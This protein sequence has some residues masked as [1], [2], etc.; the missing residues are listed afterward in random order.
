MDAAGDVVINVTTQML[1][2][3]GS[4]ISVEWKLQKNLIM[5]SQEY[6]QAVIFLKDKS[7]AKIITGNINMIVQLVDG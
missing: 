2:L 7:V 5:L 1:E 3:I 4:V 6:M